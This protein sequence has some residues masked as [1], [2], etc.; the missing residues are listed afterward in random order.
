MGV[1]VFSSPPQYNR[2]VLK[3]TDSSIASFAKKR[4][5]LAGGV[6]V[7]DSEAFLLLVVRSIA[8]GALTILIDQQLTVYV[9]TG[10]AI[11]FLV[12]TI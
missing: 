8:Y 9:I 5:Y 3:K 2:V 1:Q 7:I 4:P 6:V 10:Y 11:S 12:F